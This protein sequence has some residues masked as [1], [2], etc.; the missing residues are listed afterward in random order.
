MRSVSGE[1][2]SPGPL[3]PGSVVRRNQDRLAPGAL[4]RG[5]CHASIHPRVA[6]T[7]RGGGV[8]AD[9]ISL[10]RKRFLCVCPKPEVF[11][12]QKRG[13]IK[14]TILTSVLTSVLLLLIGTS[15]V[16][17]N[18]RDKDWIYNPATITTM[19]G[20][21][22]TCQSEGWWKPDTGVSNGGEVYIS[23]GGPGHYIGYYYDPKGALEA[24]R[25]FDFEGHKFGETYEFFF[26]RGDVVMGVWRS[27]VKGTDISSERMM[28]IYA[29]GKELG[30]ANE[31]DL[32]D[33]L[34]IPEPRRILK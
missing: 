29:P 25:Y 12:K 18:R 34:E 15:N 28:T 1:Q 4:A 27:E 10:W 6:P 8:G 17:C 23:Y 22:R 11:E 7:P 16:A 26:F 14:I 33:W 2:G 19:A 3:R 31:S 21:F 5:G 9:P 30:V 32:W 20:Y 13:R 24:V